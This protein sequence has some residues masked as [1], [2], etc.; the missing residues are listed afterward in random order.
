MTLLALSVVLALVAAVAV[1]HPLWARRTALLADVAPGEVLDAEARRRVAL[2]SLKE[3]EY[4]YAAGKLDDA[5][6]RTLRERL[7]AEA[8]RAIRAVDR[9]HGV[10]PVPAAAAGEPAAHACGFVNPA[11]SRFCAR[12]GTRLA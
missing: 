1:V 6:Y 8:L 10:A 4:D 11:G 2:A 9:L 12:C 5:D 7:S 3:V